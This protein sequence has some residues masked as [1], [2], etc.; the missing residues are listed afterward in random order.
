MQATVI[1]QPLSELDHNQEITVA[2]GV[3]VR[4]VIDR[5]GADL[6]YTRDYVASI[7]GTSIR[8]Y[9][10]VLQNGDQLVFR[11]GSKERGL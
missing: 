11:V 8:D 9:N 10:T 5:Y 2:A 4:E 6:G 7:N 3:T 1:L